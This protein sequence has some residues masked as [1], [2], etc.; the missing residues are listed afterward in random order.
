VEK[1]FE[2]FSRR[3]VES[4]EGSLFCASSKEEEEEVI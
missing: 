3:E 2:L 1:E 4:S